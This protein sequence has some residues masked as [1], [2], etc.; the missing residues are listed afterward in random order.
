MSVEHSDLL[1][2]IPLFQTLG[3]QEIDA[4]CRCVVERKYAPGEM[5]FFEGDRCEGMFIVARG[6]VKIFKVPASGVEM[7]IAVESAPSAV[8]ELAMFDGGTYPASVK[9]VDEVD[10]LFI[11]K[12][13]LFEVCR[14]Y[15]DIALKMLAIVGRRLRQLV[16]TLESVTFGSIRQRLARFLL[17]AGEHADGGAFPLPMTHQEL[18]LRLGT[19]REVVSR[20]LSRFQAEGFIRLED[21]NVEIRDPE[22][23]RREAETEM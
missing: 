19:V 7:V 22:G 15:P 14:H 12:Q 17:E 20:N 10:V 18:A 11:D 23:L 6:Q 2:K 1:T 21:T 8:G 13:G 3:Q 5:L 16:S 9:A 4:L